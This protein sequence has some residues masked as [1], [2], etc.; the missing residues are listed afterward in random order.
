MALT[1]GSKLGPYEIQSPLG[2]G[3]MGE[4][5]RARDSR[6]GRD[7]AI[8]VLPDHLSADPELKQRMEREARAISSLNHPNICTLH[9]IG[10]QDGV[11]F[12]VM[13][14]L[15]G[16]TLADRLTKGPLPLDQ[17]LK[18]GTEIAQA[19]EKAH[20]QGIIHR[21]LK[22]AN[23]MLTKAGAKLM[24]FG[25]AKP[26]LSIS[27]QAV[28]TFT[29]STPTM[30]MATLVSASSP[31][32]QRGSIV[33]TFQYMAPESLQGA[34]ADAR[35]DIFSLGCVLYEM[36]T[37][38]RAFEGKSQLSVFTAILE[39]DPDPI[40]VSQP[41]APPLLDLVVTGCLAKDP[42]ERFQ[43]AHDVAM[44]LRS[45]SALRAV[46]AEKEKDSSPAPAP[47]RL[48][49]FAAVAAAIILGV[50]AGFFLHRSA[51]AAPGVVAFIN[52]PTDSHFRLTSDLAGPPVLSPDGTSI[53]FTATTADA[54]T[55][56]WVRP[57]NSADAHSLPDTGE[58]IFPFWSPDSRSLGFFSGGKLKTIEVGATTSQTLCD[59][60]LGR[61]GAWSSAG[62]IVFAASPVTGLSQISAS[63]GSPTPLTTLDLAVHT[64][65]RWPTFLPDGKHYLYFAMNHDPA[66]VSNNAIYYAS[67]D[68]RENRLLVRTQSNAIY[69]AGF[70]LFSRGDQLM[71]QPF[72]AHNGKLSGDPQA[73]AS[74]VLNDVSTWHT[75][76]SAA[77]NG[78]LTFGNG[79]FGGVQLVW[80]GRDGKEAGV[81]ADNLKNLN[82]ARLSP[83]GDRI[84][85]GIDNGV[86]DIWLLDLARGVRTRLTFGPTGNTLPVWSPDGKWV[87]YSS[88]R[89]SGGGIY[90]KPA[91]GT[92]SEELLVPDDNGM[93]YAPDDWSHDGK[94]LFYSTNSYTQKSDG[95]WATSIDGDRKPHEVLA[96]GTNAVLS[97]NGRWLA[98]SSTESGRIEIYVEAYG[99]GKGKWQVSPNGGQVPH[100]SSDGKEL[101]YFDLSQNLLAVPVK[102]VGSALEFGAP[103]TMVSQWTVITF[104]FYTPTPD[105]KRFLLERVS[106][107]VNQPITLITNF[108]AG[109][110]K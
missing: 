63:G 24:D 45:V 44:N 65:H 64:S 42:A 55:S 32:T 74:G 107:Q 87:A 104:P 29:P 88:L 46:P 86:N 82:F 100:W 14:L 83:Q 22:P 73:V 40:S 57:V 19:L 68:G 92:G 70:L 23:I 2:A 78:L 103:L 26:S 21:D 10:S 20:A 93:V 53:A 60:Q 50:L 18:I 25:L 15:E 72:D 13:E 28:G 56:L 91:D 51:P 8:K 81:A 34:E 75:S 52:P 38:R 69:A 89:A 7:V 62:V 1:P 102:E 96:H 30:N 76:A 95:V 61:G 67:L 108:T 17:V 48:L 4:V 80:M 105:S 41:L 98:Y 37:G 12:L 110:R 47:N 77:D 97:P 3:G 36:L 94:T 85:L 6:L 33:G 66:K 54:K 58:A 71:A 31:L 11:N 16:Q 101:Y 43:S 5:Y 84:A 49:W 35:S 109:L 90:R 106:Q 27:P 39:K 79:S 59:A 9:D 99:G